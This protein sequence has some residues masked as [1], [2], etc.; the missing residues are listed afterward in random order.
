ML[1]DMTAS[2]KSRQ[3]QVMVRKPRGAAKASVL[4]VRLEPEELE[5]ITRAAKN[6]E[7]PCSISWFALQATLARARKV[8]GP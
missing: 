7:P 3:P 2:A 8:L 6:T 1:R 4:F 5:L